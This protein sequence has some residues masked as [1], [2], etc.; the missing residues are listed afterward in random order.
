MIEY[1]VNNELKGIWKEAIAAQ[2]VSFTT[3]WSG[4]IDNVHNVPVKIV[5]TL[6]KHNGAIFD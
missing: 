6:T 1:L 2:C 3:D 4:N 5:D